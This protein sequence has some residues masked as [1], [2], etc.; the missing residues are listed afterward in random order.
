MY[1]TVSCLHLFSKRQLAIVYQF[2]QNCSWQ[3]FTSFLRVPFV[4]QAQAGPIYI[5]C[6][7]QANKLQ[8]TCKTNN[9][10]RTC[11]SVYAL[12]QRE[13]GG[14]KRQLISGQTPCV[15][16]ISNPN[17]FAFFAPVRISVALACQ[18]GGKRPPFV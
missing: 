4:W 5:A 12:T 17:I 13:D 7:K 9:T 14:T 15:M 8:N 18:Q 6:R 10:Y 2:S 16:Q 11:S 1:T 3:L